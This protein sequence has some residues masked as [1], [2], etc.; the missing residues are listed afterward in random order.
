MRIVTAAAFVVALLPFAA[1]AEGQSGSR[2]AAGGAHMSSYVRHHDHDPHS[3]WSQQNGTGQVLGAP[4]RHENAGAHPRSGKSHWA[5]GT[6]PRRA[7]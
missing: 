5:A 4:M 7:H 2:Q 1:Q 3:L 6:A